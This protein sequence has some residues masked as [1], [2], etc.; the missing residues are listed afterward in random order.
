MTA[1]L[2]WLADVTLGPRCPLCLERLRGHNGLIRHK[3]DQHA[4]DRL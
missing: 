1:L 2:A 4:G 3:R